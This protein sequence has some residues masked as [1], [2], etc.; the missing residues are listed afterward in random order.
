M[1]GRGGRREYGA[2]FLRK[3]G[4]GEKNGKEAESAGG[5]D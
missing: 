1:G 2:A 4:G 5:W 3:R